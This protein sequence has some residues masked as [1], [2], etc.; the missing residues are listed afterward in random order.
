MIIT[1]LFILTIHFF[2][3]CEIRDEKTISIV[4]HFINN[5]SNKYSHNNKGLEYTDPLPT[6]K[7]DETSKSVPFE[8]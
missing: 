2:P 6:I 1:K 8:L 5:S 3:I 4:H 7:A